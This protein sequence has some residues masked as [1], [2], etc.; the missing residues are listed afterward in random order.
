MDGRVVEGSRGVLA[1]DEGDDKIPECRVSLH[2]R[3]PRTADTTK[4]ARI[5]RTPVSGHPV[6]QVAIIRRIVGGSDVT[7]MRIE[8]DEVQCF[9]S[10]VL[11]IRQ[12]LCGHRRPL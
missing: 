12:H 6:R 10:Y 11:D 7:P 1:I 5:T 9:G 2:D 8:K 4:V 3:T